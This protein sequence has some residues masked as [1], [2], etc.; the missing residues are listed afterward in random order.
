MFTEA[1]LIGSFALSAVA[2]SSSFGGFSGSSSVGG[3][4]QPSSKTSSIN[5]QTT[6]N[7]FIDG[8]TTEHFVGAVVAADSCETTYALVCTAGSFGSGYLEQ[9][10]DPSVTVSYPPSC[11]KHLQA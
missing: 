6:M 7:L 4:V 5:A 11:C 9:S 2:Q 3:G 1:L 10:C 8:A